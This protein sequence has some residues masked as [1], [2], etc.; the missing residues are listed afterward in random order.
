MLKKLEI[1]PLVGGLWTATSLCL[2]RKRISVLSPFRGSKAAAKAIG[3]SK[4]CGPPRP[5][6]I[7]KNLPSQ[8]R[9][10]AISLRR[11]GW[12]PGTRSSARRAGSESNS[13][14]AAAALRRPAPRRSARGG[15]NGRMFGT[16]GRMRKTMAP[17]P[18]LFGDLQIKPREGRGAAWTFGEAEIGEMRRLRFEEI[19]KS[20]CR[21][22][23]GDPRSGDF[24]YCGLTPVGG[25]SYCA[26][27]CRMA[28]RPPQARPSRQRQGLHRHREFV[29]GGL[30]T[31]RG[32]YAPAGVAILS[33]TQIR[34]GASAPA[35]RR[36]DADWTRRGRKP[37]SWAVVSI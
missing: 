36:V 16:L 2:P 28:Y 20:A 24:A 31:A 25:Q 8:E 11:S 5:S 6:R 37:A 13:R 22:P 4:C 23:L 17:I 10:R 30:R 34:P 7:S 1:L 9:A 27:H 3:A 33:N 14:A 26:G 15:R 19:R 32:A 18:P 29:A 35:S 12:D 21:W